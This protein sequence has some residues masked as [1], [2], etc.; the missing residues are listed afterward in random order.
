MKVFS[1]EVL[2]QNKIAIIVSHDINLATTFAD[3]ILYASLPEKT[4]IGQISNDARFI[5]DNSNWYNAKGEKIEDIKS[6]LIQKI[7]Q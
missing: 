3:E 4:P 7:A 2:L 6:V 5:R 1:E